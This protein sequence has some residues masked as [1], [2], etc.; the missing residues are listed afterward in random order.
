[1]RWA[2]STT[3]RSHSVCPSSASSSSLRASWSIRA[4]SSGRSSKAEPPKAR[5]GEIGAEEV[6]AQAELEE[7]LVLPLLDQAA[8]GDDQAA[9]DVVAQHQLLDVEPGHDRLA[10]AGVVGE[11]EA[12]RSARQQLAVDRPDLVGQR[13]DVAVVTA[14]IGSKRPASLMR[15]ASATS[16]K[17]VASASKGRADFSTISSSASSR[18]WSTRSPSEPSGDRK[19]SCAASAPCISTETTSTIAPGMTPLRRWPAWSSSSRG[20]AAADRIGSPG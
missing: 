10:G 18:R 11:E 15:W 5:L 12:Q 9:L 14:S 4:I 2:S 1:M 13:L 7:Q 19:T 20:I 8:G 3:I 16:L 17:L 6:E